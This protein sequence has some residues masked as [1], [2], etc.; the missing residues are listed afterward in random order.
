MRELKHRVM[1]CC[2]VGW[3][4]LCV[5]FGSMVVAGWGRGGVRRVGFCWMGA[6]WCGVVQRWRVG[7]GGLVG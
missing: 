4:W 5:V 3:G 6:I 7:V 2:V 1:G